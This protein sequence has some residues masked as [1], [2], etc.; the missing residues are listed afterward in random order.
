MPIVLAIKAKGYI[1]QGRPKVDEKKD[2]KVLLSFTQKEYDRLKKL[3]LMLGKSTLTATIL[4]FMHEG[5]QKVQHEFE[6]VWERE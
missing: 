2:K 4:F 1:M 5:M 3:Q 6:N